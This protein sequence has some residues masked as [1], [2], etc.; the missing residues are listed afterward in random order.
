M[1]P[2]YNSARIPVPNAFAKNKTGKKQMAVECLKNYIGC[3]IRKAI[4]KD[5]LA[6]HFK[7]KSD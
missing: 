2:D 1:V 3:L 7:L 5:Y 4:G 6:Y